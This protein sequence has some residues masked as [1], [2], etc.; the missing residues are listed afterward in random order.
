MNYSKYQKAIFQFVQDVNKGSLLYDG[1]QHCLVNAGPGSGKT[2]TIVEACKYVPP[3]S[4]TIL[5][6]FGK[7]IAEELGKRIPRHCES[8]TLNSFGYWICRD[9]ITRMGSPTEWKSYN[10]LK[11]LISE[12]DLKKCSYVTKQLTGL[13]KN[14]LVTD[15]IIVNV[16]DIIKRNAV[17]LPEKMNNFLEIFEEVYKRNINQL[18]VLDWDDQ[19]FQPVFRNWNIK[20]YDWVFVDEAQDLSPL[21]M[22]LV[23]RI[24]GANGHGVF[25]GDVKQAIYMF[26]GA[27]SNALDKIKNHFKAKELPL[28][29][30]YRCPTKVIDEAKKIYK[31]I[32]HPEVNSNGEGI[33]GP[34]VKGIYEQQV[35]NND[36]VLCRTVAP[37]I[38][39]CLR[40]LS[41]HKPA[42]VKGREIGEGLISLIN[43]VCEEDHLMW[44]DKFNEKL[45]TYCTQQF[46]ILGKLK[47]EAA[48]ILLEDQQE[49]LKLLFTTCANVNDLIH[50]IKTIIVDNGTGICFMTMHKSKGLENKNVYIIR[51]DLI[52]HKRAKTQ[53]QLTQEDNLIFIAI[54]RSQHALY[55]VQKDQG[56]R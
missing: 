50:L 52:P 14:Y 33:V 7:A 24:I 25:V 16:E 40:M 21:D 44:I 9:N 47:R 36:F 19:K 15:N 8:R 38:K 51:R 54:T 1:P 45:D 29:I 32:E 4:K 3:Q 34:L 56:E 43:K 48:I 49:S 28:P 26:R 12:E 10:I 39:Y 18:D 17:E 22:Q 11:E 6:S 31:D 46:E 27:A 37:L 42:Y 23:S 2:T 35:G 53:E 55:F 20:N 41:L 30:C 13:C 5:M